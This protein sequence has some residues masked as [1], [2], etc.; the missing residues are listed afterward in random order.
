MVNAENPKEGHWFVGVAPICRGALVCR[1]S[2]FGAS[3]TRD[4]YC[5]TRATDL[6]QAFALVFRQ[7]YSFVFLKLFLFSI[8]CRRQTVCK[9]WR[10]IYLPR[11]RWRHNAPAL[12]LFPLIYTF[13]WR[14]RA[15][16]VLL[17][18]N[19]HLLSV[20]RR[21]GREPTPLTSLRTGSEVLSPARNKHT[22]EY[23]QCILLH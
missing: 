7:F 22:T 10:M 3:Q 5:W 20:T 21:S 23:K 15:A 16:C 13:C 4:F 14:Y 9:G 8:L 11:A 18:G 17:P 12:L 6:S 2:L 19:G 1:E